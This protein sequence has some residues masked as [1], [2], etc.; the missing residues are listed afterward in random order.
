[1][2]VKWSPVPLEN[3]NGEVLGYRVFY[4]KVNASSRANITVDSQEGSCFII[5]GLRADTNYSFQILAFTGKGDGPRSANY[6]AKAGINIV[7]R[8]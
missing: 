7:W 2:Q 6:F 1:V 8:R 5:D 4:S 3:A